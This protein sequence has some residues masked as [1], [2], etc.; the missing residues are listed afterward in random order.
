[1]NKSTKSLTDFAR[2]SRADGGEVRGTD[3]WARV[4]GL[5]PARK[6]LAK[7]YLAEAVSDIAGLPSEDIARLLSLSE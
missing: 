4:S 5:G 1:M 2:E 7:G 3:G 6:M